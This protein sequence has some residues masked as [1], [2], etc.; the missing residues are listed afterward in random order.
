MSK[1]ST[2]CFLG[3]CTIQVGSTQEPGC[4]ETELYLLNYSFPTMSE[5]P[6]KQSF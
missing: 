3:M 4:K 1:D 6:G 2:T 5:F